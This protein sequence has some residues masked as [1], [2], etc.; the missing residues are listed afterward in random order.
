[1]S[2][3]RIYMV[4]LAAYNKGFLHGVWIDATSELSDMQDEIDKRLAA[5]P[6]TVAEEYAIHDHEGFDGAGLESA[7]EVAEFIA[8]F[9]N[10]AGALLNHCGNLV[11]ARRAAEDNYCGCHVKKRNRH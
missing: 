7:H 4:D 6:V 10:F 9:P 1:M 3:I 11:E 2:E 5:S 8:A